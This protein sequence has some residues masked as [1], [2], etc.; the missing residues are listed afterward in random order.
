MVPRAF[1]MRKDLWAGHL[2]RPGLV[3]QWGQIETR[4][5]TFVSEVRRARSRSGEREGGAGLRPAD[6]RP[7]VAEGAGGGREAGRGEQSR[8]GRASGPALM[9]IKHPPKSARQT[10][11]QPG[12]LVLVESIRFVLTFVPMET[13]WRNADVFMNSEYRDRMCVSVCKCTQC[14]SKSISMKYLFS[15]NQISERVWFPTC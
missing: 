2:G 15:S 7:H 9:E 11:H 4:C 1:Q 8:A 10:L 3:K 13:S 12:N 5:L 14:I 6:G